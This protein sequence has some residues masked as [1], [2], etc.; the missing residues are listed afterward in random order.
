MRELLQHDK[1]TSSASSLPEKENMQNIVL[2]NMFTAQ[3]N[4]KLHH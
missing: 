3:V 1:T 4:I 2:E